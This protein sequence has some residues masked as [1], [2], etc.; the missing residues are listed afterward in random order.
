VR[1][2]R[3]ALVAAAAAMALAAAATGC[4]SSSGSAPSPGPASAVPANAALYADAIVHPQGDVKS[5]LQSSL[6]KLLGT[7]DPGGFIVSRLDRALRSEHLTYSRDVEPWLGERAGIYF[8]SFGSNP[9]GAVV[10]ETTDPKAA[11]ATLRKA[12]LRNGDKVHEETHRRVTIEV[13]GSDTF[14]AVGDLAVT[15]PRAGVEAAIDAATGSSLADSQ[16]YGKS[17]DAAPDD[18][19]LTVW[20][21]PSRV[22]D[23]LTSEGQLSAAGAAQLRAVA[24]AFLGSPIAAWGEAA[25]GYLALEASFARPPG[26]SGGP[27]L[28]ESF[29]AD[30]WLAFGFHEGVAGAALGLRSP[31][32]GAA[33]GL[34]GSAALQRAFADAGIDP[35]I[36]RRWVGDV[37]GFIRGSSLLDLGGALVIQSRD[38]AASAKT[39]DQL[40]AAFE[41]DVDV[42]TRP[43]GGGQT[44]FT[45]TPA[46]SP[47]QIVFTQRDGKVVIAL[48][49]N[50]VAD[51]LGA[52]EGLADSPT[53]KSAAGS[54]GGLAPSFYLDFQPIARLF[55]LPG[56]IQNPRFEQ[57]KPY[58]E[59]LDYLIAGGGESGDR[60]LLRLALGVRA[61]GS[62][63][64]AF[65]AARQPALAANAP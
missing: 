55:E 53:F 25:N 26:S 18:R 43:L 61:A 16:G 57:I 54:L 17:L 21:N 3:R 15:G 37:S 12:A 23:A 46:G 20:V 28:I 51:A 35:G 65:A 30:S 62:G 13:A 50:S 5:A 60:G 4:G 56:V 6:S 22:L 24:G 44:G 52:K 64:G 32:A 36:L 31:R 7:D 33:L 10:L 8:R 48:G 1:Q 27:S 63:S 39:L 58:L 40:Q 42:V 47:V 14:A 2:L 11:L 49:Q 59:R 34:P 19:V 45:V 38:Q 9:V 41:R 29:P